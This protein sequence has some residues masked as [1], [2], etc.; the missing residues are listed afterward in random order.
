MKLKLKIYNAP[1]KNN[2][3]DNNSHI[4]HRLSKIK[5]MNKP[6]VF[7]DLETTGSDSSKDTT[8][9][10]AAIRIEPDGT[11]K[12]MKFFCNPGQPIEPGATEIHGISDEMVASLPRIQESKEDIL[13]FF[14]GADIG[15]YNI[16]QFDIPILKREIPELNL[17]NVTVF[18]LLVMDRKVRNH[19]LASA[20]EAWTGEPM[21]PERAHDAIYDNECTIALLP[22]LLDK[23]TALEPSWVDD[24]I[25]ETQNF[26]K[27]DGE[28]YFNF[29]KNRGE[30][31]NSCQSYLKWMLSSDFSK[32]TKDFIKKEL[33]V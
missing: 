6:I 25:I 23:Y 13:N 19:K 7:F 4:N 28:I 30:L 12:E 21:D 20:F 32:G 10:F 31:A 17:D 24:Q 3:R 5:Q 29:G 33:L 11:K 15:G 9:Q 22:H 1:R 26:I 18:D 2:T 27:K 8:L 14:K 16:L